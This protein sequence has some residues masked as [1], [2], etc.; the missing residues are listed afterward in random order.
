MRS[1]NIIHFAFSP[2]M[3]WA[4]EESNM[5][6]FKW[7]VLILTFRQVRSLRYYRER[8]AC[9]THCRHYIAIILV[10][11]MLVAECRSPKWN[12][13]KCFK[14]ILNICLWYLLKTSKFENERRIK[15]AT[16]KIVPVNTHLVLSATNLFIEAAWKPSSYYPSHSHCTAKGSKENGW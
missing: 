12:L 13:G 1:R 3:Y 14:S 4:L 10:G 7:L 9:F 16:P 15:K 5:T 6:S 2:E 8:V 11:G